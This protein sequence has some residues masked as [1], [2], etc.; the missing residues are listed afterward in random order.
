MHQ[1]VARDRFRSLQKSNCEVKKKESHGHADLRI[2]NRTLEGAI[3]TCFGEGC[4]LQKTF[5]SN[6]S[7][8]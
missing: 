1:P 7:D 8:N 2:G 4:H 5:A 6:N 3:V